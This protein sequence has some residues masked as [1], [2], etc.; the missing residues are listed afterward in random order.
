LP[1]IGVP[2]Y[3][4]V[5]HRFTYPYLVRGNG[6]CRGPRHA[7]GVVW[8]PRLDLRDDCFDASRLR[9]RLGVR[10]WGSRCRDQGLGFWVKG[11]EF[12]G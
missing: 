12:R 10:V 7:S 1:N 9:Q 5:L 11:F 4:G 2:R 3:I 8:L 6:A